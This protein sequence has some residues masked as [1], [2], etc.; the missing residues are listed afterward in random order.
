MVRNQLPA[1]LVKLKLLP[2]FVEALE[3]TILNRRKVKDEQR[4]AAFDESGGV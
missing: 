2:I 1:Q 4:I 3:R